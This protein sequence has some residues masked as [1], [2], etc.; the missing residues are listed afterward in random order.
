MYDITQQ[1][2]MTS[3]PDV[4]DSLTG[5]IKTLVSSFR[6]FSL[7]PDDHSLSINCIRHI[8]SEMVKFTDNTGNLLLE[9]EKDGIYSDK[10]KYYSCSGDEDPFVYPLVRDGILN[11]EFMKGIQPYEIN[12]FFSIIKKNRILPDEPESDTVTDLWQADLPH[13]RYQ[14]SEVFWDSEPVF[15]FPKSTMGF[16]EPIK[17]HDLNNKRKDGA[18]HP[19]PNGLSYEPSFFEPANL[20]G[21][22]FAGTDLSFNPDELAQ[23][24]HMVNEEEDNRG[25]DDILDLLLLVLDEISNSEDLEN[26]LINLAEE[27]LRVLQNGEVYKAFS[28]IEKVLAYHNKHAWMRPFVDSKVNH[29]MTHLAGPVFKEALT[30]IVAI[31]NQ[32]KPEDIFFFRKICMAFDSSSVLSLCDTLVFLETQA[33]RDLLMDIIKLKTRE[34]ASVIERMLDSKDIMISLI[35][36]SLLKNLKDSN[37]DVLLQRMLSHPVE[38]IRSSALDYFLEKPVSILPRIFFMIDDSSLD[39]KIKLLRF[40]GSKRAVTSESLMMNYLNDQPM[41]STNKEH[42]LSCYKVLGKCG[43][44]RSIP[45]LKNKVFGGSWMGLTGSKSFEHRAGAIMALAGLE[46]SEA[47]KL[48]KKASKSRLPVVNKAYKM[49]ME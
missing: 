27:F 26:V 32:N 29:F 42:I 48:L 44:D 15:K 47:M 18:F 7:Y 6:N 11:I 37:S 2:K 40:I 9:I 8:S 1:N 35:G 34:D 28:I 12:M 41:T 38:Q 5:I 14:A 39:I 3:I 36:I 25:E 17:L 45:F 49:F 23:L 22:Y 19:G 4:N 43:S 10:K 33:S 46:S 31:L 20:A 13:L 21:P 16:S 24:R 30:G